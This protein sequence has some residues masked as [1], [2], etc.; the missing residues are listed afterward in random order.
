MARYFINYGDGRFSASRERI[1]R[2]AEALGI[3]DKVVAY[4]P[5]DLDDDFRR[6]PLFRY[7]RGGGYWCWKPWITLDALNKTKPGDIICYCDSG[8]SLFPSKEWEEWFRMLDKYDMVVFRNM[9][10]NKQYVKRYMLDY[11]KPVLGDWWGE[12]YQVVT[13]AYFVRNTPFVRR[14]FEEEMQ[15]F[16]EDMVVDV[17]PEAMGREAPCFVEHR[18]D[19]SL[20]SALVFERLPERKIKILSNTFEAR[21]KGQAIL[22]TRLANGRESSISLEKNWLQAHVKRPVGN[23]V[24]AIDQWYWRKRNEASLRR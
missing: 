23:M 6:N 19:Q 14:F 16:T 15:L 18:H 13:G 11:F 3:F 24:R 21:I 8:C 4:S 12:Y 20:F 5:D 22:A 9:Y 1:A 2:E 7:A 17:P 10:R